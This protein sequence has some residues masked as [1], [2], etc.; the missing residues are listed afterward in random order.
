MSRKFL[1]L[2][3]V[4]IV[5]LWSGNWYLLSG[6]SNEAR[7]TFG[8]M[9]G[10]VN[11]LFSGLAFLGVVYAIILQKTEL[12]LQRKELELTRNELKKSAEAQERSEKAL[13]IQAKAME[14]TALIN[15][16][17]A[18]IQ[19]LSS[20]IQGISLSGKTSVVEENKRRR[21]A[22]IKKHAV[23]TRKLDEIINN[24]LDS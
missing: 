20:R 6:M 9:F 24:I 22:L 14:Q 21:E 5:F 19:S 7:G 2:S 3:V 8:D 4:A 17:T 18:S 13:S 12:S 16:L 23:L 15:T 10:A 1:I 11:S